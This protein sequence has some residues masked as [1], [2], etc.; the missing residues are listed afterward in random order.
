ME[1]IKPRN[2]QGDKALRVTVQRSTRK[3]SYYDDEVKLKISKLKIKLE[4][5]VKLNKELLNN[6]IENEKYYKNR[7][8]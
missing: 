3:C 1:K 6:K 8:G 2:E 7:L 5:E 4:K